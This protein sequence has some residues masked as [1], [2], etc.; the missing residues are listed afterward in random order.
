MEPKIQLTRI[1][2]RLENV[3]K[4]FEITATISTH[5]KYGHVGYLKSEASLIRE[6][7]KRLESQP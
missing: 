5:R 6:A 1:A 2:D 4:E 7:L 3:A